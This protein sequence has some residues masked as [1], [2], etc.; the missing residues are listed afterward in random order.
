MDR[1]LSSLHRWHADKGLSLTWVIKQRPMKRMWE[2][3]YSIYRAAVSNQ[4]TSPRV[5]KI[6]RNKRTAEYQRL[7]RWYEVSSLLFSSR[8][9][10]NTLIMKARLGVLR[11][12]LL[13]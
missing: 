11:R 9:E 8:T 5:E 4:A 1:L 7:V 10:K 13:T 3:D 6:D 2:Y 12:E